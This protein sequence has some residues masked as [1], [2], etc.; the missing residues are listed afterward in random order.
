[1]NKRSCLFLK[2]VSMTVIIAAL[3]IVSTLTDG[4]QAKIT[5]ESVAYP[6]YTYGMQSEQTIACE[7]IDSVAYVSVQDYLTLSGS[8]EINSQYDLKEDNNRWILT[9]SGKTYIFDTEKNQVSLEIIPELYNSLGEQVSPFLMKTSIETNCGAQ[10][11]TAYTI[12]LDEYGMMIYAWDDKVY[13]PFPLA[14]M[15]LSDGM[16]AFYMY[17]GNGIYLLDLYADYEDSNSAYPGNYCGN[18][19]FNKAIFQKT[20]TKEEAAFSYGLICLN[21]DYFYGFPGISMIE[22][23]P[24]NVQT[25]GLDAALDMTEFGRTAKEFLLS[26]SWADY[27]CG[28]EM[29]DVLFRDGHCML[30]YAN[31]TYYW[32]QKDMCMDSALSEQDTIRLR[33]LKKWLYSTDEYACIE[34]KREENSQISRGIWKARE[35]LWKMPS[36]ISWGEDTYHEQG[37][38]AIISFD[39]FMI[40]HEAWDDYYT[41][42]CKGEVPNS[43]CIGTVYYGLKKASENPEIQ[44][45]VIDLTDNLGGE[46]DAV[47]MIL[48]FMTGKA[49]FRT[50]DTQTGVI[51]TVNYKADC[52]FDGLFDDRDQSKYDFKYIILV[53]ESTFSAGSALALY[54]S[55]EEMLI[56]GTSIG[57][58]CCAQ[59]FYV[60][61]NGIL[62]CLSSH[63][64][65]VNSD[66][67]TSD[68]VG[69]SFID[70]FLNI[71]DLLVDYYGSDAKDCS[72]FYDTNNWN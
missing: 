22:E 51:T 24:Y 71:P 13:L 16:D 46:S 14:S 39:N 34:Q 9:G 54:G 7:I 17:S 38:T 69:K 1:M 63:I 32:N 29:L 19:E 8:T 26:Q 56:V 31:P 58:G 15:I 6:V 66:G 33:D 62:Y 60:D 59:R 53:S 67:I 30:P 44:H 41:N 18:A 65:V 72:V 28:L 37:A 70:L 42:G 5:A 20:R 35:E 2:K 47:A 49:Y 45:V 12:P 10:S 68:Q 25:R 55:D 64:R 48:A 50:E 3:I 43:D 11:N 61:G 36:G 52:N 4:A 40:D 57:G 23:D 27:I 21:I